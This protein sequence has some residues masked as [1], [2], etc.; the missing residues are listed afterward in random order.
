MKQIIIGIHGLGNK[1]EK[2]VLQNW[3]L[4]S[5]KEGLDRINKERTKIPFELA[6]WADIIYPKPYNLK[7]KDKDNPLYLDEVY[8][9]GKFK[10]KNNQSSIKTK[11]IKYIEEQ[12]DKVFLNDDLSI[13]F[14]N[15]TDK[16]MHHYFSELETYYNDDCKSGVNPD[17]NVKNEIQNRLKTIFD[18]YKGYQILLIGHSMGSIVA[19][20]VLSDITSVQPIDTF[21]TIGSPLGVPVIVSKIFAEQKKRNSKLKKPVAPDN[22]SEAWY[23]LSDIEDKVALDHTLNDD[24]SENKYKVSAKDQI[25]INDYEIN[26]EENHHKSFGY[27][28]TPEMANIINSFL[29]SK[30]SD[31]VY[32][33]FKVITDKIK[34][35]LENMINIFARREK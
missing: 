20:D 1:P 28:R 15:V 13:N 19:F 27:L 35:G 17:C 16:L 26:G 9:K 7:I 29:I 33:S 25:V 10:Q 23:N 3:W 32:Q 30:K 18:K 14:K 34:I 8:K 21:V 24:F 6:Y 31:S 2:S 5:I 12:L 11:I 4:K 22:I